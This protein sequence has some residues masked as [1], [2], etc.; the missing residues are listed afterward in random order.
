MGRAPLKARAQQATVSSINESDH[1]SRGSGVPFSPLCPE[2]SACH[3]PQCPLSP[4]QQP[5][6]CLL[7][8][9]SAETTSLSHF[10]S[11]PPLLSLQR[12][13]TA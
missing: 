3:P 9:A 12:P 5:H 7:P 6:A 13:L 2:S 1:V 11:S 8:L 4:P 10:S